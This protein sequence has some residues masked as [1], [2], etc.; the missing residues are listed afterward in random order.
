MSTVM[1][2]GGG[3]ARNGEFF[4]LHVTMLFSLDMYWIVGLFPPG[5]D[6]KKSFSK[7][8]NSVRKFISVKPLNLL[9]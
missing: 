7:K 3:G 1:L 4:L 2:R 8:S 9:R 6:E 5:T